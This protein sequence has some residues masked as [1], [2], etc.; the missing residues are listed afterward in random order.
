M[1]STMCTQM[2]SEVRPEMRSQKLGPPP[3]PM[4]F[5]GVVSRRPEAASQ[6]LIATYAALAERRG[7]LI[8]G[9]LK[10][11]SPQQWKH[12]P[13]DDAID[14]ASGYQW[15]YHSHA[16]DDRSGTTEHGHIHLFARRPLWSR[17]LQS[18]A[19]KAF[20]RLTGNPTKHVET[21]HLL[22]V[23]MSAKGVPE[24]VFTVNSWVTGD[25]MLSAPTTSRLLREMKLNTGH[26]AVDTVLECVVLLCSDEIEQVLIRRD[27]ALSSHRKPLADKSLEVLSEAAIDLDSKLSS[28]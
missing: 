10:G 28:T 26:P 17:R 22:S 27:Q 11:Q 5:Q 25:L 15:F 13:A 12:Y 9:L 19:E 14:R 24:S 1:R 18:G 4:Q 23:G 21:R 8:A 20:A 7:H 3:Q 16:P 6:R 2:C